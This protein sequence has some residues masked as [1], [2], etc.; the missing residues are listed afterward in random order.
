MLY[1]YLFAMQQFEGGDTLYDMSGLF[2]QLK[3]LLDIMLCTFPKLSPVDLK[4]ALFAIC[5]GY[6][7]GAATFV[8][9]RDHNTHHCLKWLQSTMGVGVVGIAKMVN[10]DM[11]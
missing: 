1:Y 10:I 8:A 2:E 3:R 4:A 11:I 9:I 5:P 6:A 7:D